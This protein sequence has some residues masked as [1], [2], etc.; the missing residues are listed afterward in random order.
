MRAVFSLITI[1]FVVCVSYTISSF[2]EI[3]LDI[4]EDD[5]RIKEI[6]HLS[7][8]NTEKAPFA[9][10]DEEK[11]YGTANNAEETTPAISVSINP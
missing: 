5:L 7:N 3:P 8:D 1:I 11:S 6:I 10:G 4:L 2:S 9:N